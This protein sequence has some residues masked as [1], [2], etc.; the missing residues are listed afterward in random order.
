MSNPHPVRPK[1]GLPAVA[2]TAFYKRQMKFLE[3]L[4]EKSGSTNRTSFKAHPRIK[5]LISGKKDQVKV[6]RG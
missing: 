4:M 3:W 5:A 6:D 2:Q 1:M